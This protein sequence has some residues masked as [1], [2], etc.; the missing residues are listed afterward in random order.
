MK[1]LAIPIRM[2]EW[3]PHCQEEVKSSLVQNTAA[4]KNIVTCSKGLVAL[5]TKKIQEATLPSWG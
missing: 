3:S 1:C 2:G 5:K 4:G